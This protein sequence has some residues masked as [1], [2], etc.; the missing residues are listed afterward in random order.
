MFYKLQHHLPNYLII[1]KKLI[2][3]ITCLFLGMVVFAQEGVNFQHLTFN[4]ALAKA[5]TEKKL[6]FVDCYTTWC[7]PC[8][9]MTTEIFP[10]KEAGEFFNPRFVC[11]KFD[12]EQGEGKELRT[13]LAVKAFPSFFIIRPDGTIQHSIVGSSKALDG[14]IARVNKGLNEK[15]SLLYLTQLYQKGK[16]NKKQLLAYK[17]ALSDAYDKENAEKI[18]KELAA[19]ITEKDKLK[20]EFWSIFE[21]GNCAVGSSDF[22]LL[23]AN[24]SVFEKN[25]GKDKLDEYLYGKY[26]RAVAGHIM[27]RTKEERIPLADL[28]QQIEKLDIQKKDQLMKKLE[29]AELVEAGNPNNLITVI[30]GKAETLTGEDVWTVI[31]ALRVISDKATKADYNRMI[32]IFEKM[33]ANPANAEIEDSLDSF[34][35]HYKS[36]AYVGTYFEDLT[37]EQALEKSKKS[38]KRLFIDCYTSWCGPCKHMTAQVFP[39]EKLG[40]YLNPRFICVKFDMEKGEGPE[41]SKKFDVHAYPTFVILNPDG[42]I[43]HKLVGGNR[44]GGDFLKRV[45]EAFD[46]DKALGMLDKKYE[47]GERGKEFMVQYFKVLEDLRAKET[48]NKVADQLYKSLSDEEKM[49]EKYW[50][51]FTNDNLSCSAEA[52]QYLL[53]NREKFNQS[54]GQEKIDQRLGAGVQGKLIQIFSGRDKVTTLQDLDQMK[55][56][57]TGLKLDSEKSMLSRINI[58]KAV[59]SKDMNR[60]LS[61]CELERNQIPAQEFPF[62]M[63]TMIKEKATPAQMNRWVKLCKKVVADCKDQKLTDQLNEFVQK[64]EVK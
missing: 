24:L 5:K 36:L 26:D 46:P 40:D 16:M 61:A 11:V 17:E 6:V 41:L 19:Q 59:V 2:S 55:K 14:F 44:D 64:L 32:I 38:G 4:E 13:K 33:K 20:K 3:F 49:T 22:N 30:E 7:G 45:E 57:I 56:E 39:E 10:M 42:T 51:L 53:D 23:L 28:K 58:A 27:K 8:K 1:M 18:G 21:E 63:T 29:I 25:I 12:M 37:F 60:I 47:A 54:I 50:F 15:T 35:Q 43:C 62:M 31:A 9:Y 48:L 52:R 34:V